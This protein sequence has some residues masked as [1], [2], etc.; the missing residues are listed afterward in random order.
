MFYNNLSLILSAAVPAILLPWLL[1]VALPGL[2]LRWKTSHIPII[3][4]EKGEWLDTQAVKRCA[5]NMNAILQEGYKKVA[6][7]RMEK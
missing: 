6:W 4:K 1:S 3:N 2:R 5:S 7:E